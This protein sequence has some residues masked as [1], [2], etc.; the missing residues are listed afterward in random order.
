MKIYEKSKRMIEQYL[1]SHPCVDCGETD[2]DVL[3]FDHVR[4]DKLFNIGNS[5]LKSV[6]KLQA[7]IE[8]CDVRCANCHL[9]ATKTRKQFHAA[10]REKRK[11]RAIEKTA[12]KAT[13][14]A[15]LRLFKI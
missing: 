11:P 15:Q 2:V 7:E 6:A 14:T 8:K 5:R 4:G 10:H 9:R 13:E 12:P 1:R 3:T